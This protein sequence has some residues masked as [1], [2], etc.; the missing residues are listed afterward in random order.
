ME[1]RREREAL[2]QASGVGSSSQ[3]VGL[4]GRLLLHLKEMLGYRQMS[5]GALGLPAQGYI[6]TVDLGSFIPPPSP[7]PPS[8][9]SSLLLYPT[10][11]AG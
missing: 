5:R 11:A 3:L 10:R 9:L 6:Y 2:P 4:Q 7:P 1:Q 8:F